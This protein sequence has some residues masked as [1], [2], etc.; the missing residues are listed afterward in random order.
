M[1]FKKDKKKLVSRLAVIVAHIY[2]LKHYLKYSEGGGSWLETIQRESMDAMEILLNQGKLRSEFIESLINAEVGTNILENVWK[3][4][5]KLVIKDLSKDIKIEKR[6]F[7]E[8]I[9]IDI[10][11]ELIFCLFFPKEI[12]GGYKRTYGII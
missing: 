10:K 7:P 11:C 6:D 1:S 8:S 12:R 5:V 3:E 2:K 9:P 4:A